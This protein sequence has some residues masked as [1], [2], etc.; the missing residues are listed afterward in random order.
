MHVAPGSLRV[1]SYIP[2]QISAQICQAVGHFIIENSHI[3]SGYNSDCAVLDEAGSLISELSAFSQI[4][5]EPDLLL[6]IPRNEN[7]EIDELIVVFDS[8][9]TNY[10]HFLLF[11]VARYM[12]HAKF[13]P[14]YVPVAI[15]AYT[16]RFQRNEVRFS[17]ATFEDVL[18]SSITD[19]P[20]LNLAPGMHRVR[21]LHAFWTLTSPPTDIIDSDDYFGPL[22]AL[23][24]EINL[25]RE[26]G[27]R[28]SSR[29]LVSRRLGP[30]PRLDES[31]EKIL[32]DIALRFGFDTLCL[33]VMSFE[34]QVAAFCGATIVVA[35]HGAGLANSIF[36]KAGCCIIE[37]NRR[38]AGEDTLRPWFYQ[39]ASARDMPYVGFDLDQ[40]PSALEGLG[41]YLAEKI[42]DRQ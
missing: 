17:K 15:P 41:R 5:R 1:N 25:G 23:G 33:E 19:R 6:K 30:D 37:L 32:Q 39:I 10:F 9:W 24:N 42:S 14:Q 27:Q 28:C 38:I 35:P 18:R 22:H 29:I 20:L 31:D 12:R 4:A 26:G 16:E 3:V 8:A 11:G 40:G 7:D 13:V 36:S 2:G 21:R 34:E